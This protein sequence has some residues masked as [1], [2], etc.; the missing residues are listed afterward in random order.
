V[1]G[2]LPKPFDLHATAAQQFKHDPFVLFV[3]GVIVDRVMS[4]ESQFIVP[5]SFIELYLPKGSTK[6]SEPR[7]V[8]A[9]RYELCEDL[10]QLL[11]EQA[12][13]KVF[14]L[15]ITEQDVLERIS[16]GLQVGDRIVSDD[17]GRWIIRRLAEILGWEAE[18]PII[19]PKPPRR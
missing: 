4:E 7:D 19:E 5:R 13:S 11:S 18:A 8:I 10:A 14:E 12:R 15:G 16:Q 6:P 17:E 1:H 2:R 3:P 9:E